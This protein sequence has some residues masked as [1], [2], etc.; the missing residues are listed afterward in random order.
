M[1]A[2]LPLQRLAPDREQLRIGKN[3]QVGNDLRDGSAVRLVVMG[4]KILDEVL[5]G[6]A[7]TVP[8][9]NDADVGFT[10]LRRRHHRLR[11]RLVERRV[12]GGP[13]PLL[14]RLGPCASD[15]ADIR[16][17]RRA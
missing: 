5:R 11:D 2:Q 16:A 10:T 8:V 3:G 1:A 14:T 12:L 13:L 9:A 6:I 7:V 4:P 15:D 17:G